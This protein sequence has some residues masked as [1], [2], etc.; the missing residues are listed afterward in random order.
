MSKRSFG[1]SDLDSRA[2]DFVVRRDGEEHVLSL[3]KFSLMSRIWAAR[4]FG[5]VETWEKALFPVDEENFDEAKWLEAILKTFHHLI[6]DKS[7]FE[8][9]ESLGEFLEVTP[10]VL[11]EMQKTLVWVLKGSQPIIDELDAVKKN[12]L[13]QATPQEKKAKKKTRAGRK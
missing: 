6:E 12:L 13:D 5:S 4:E 3:G 7:G 9:W 10:E 11:F 1:L 8:T 2:C